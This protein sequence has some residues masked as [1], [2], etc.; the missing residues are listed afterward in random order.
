MAHTNFPKTVREKRLEIDNK[1]FKNAKFYKHLSYEQAQE[2]FE[3]GA[4]IIHRNALY[5]AK[6]KHIPVFAEALP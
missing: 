1:K 5:Y 3:N 2:L 4:K 6:K